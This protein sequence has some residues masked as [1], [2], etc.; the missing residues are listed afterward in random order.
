MT[1]RLPASLKGLKIV[2]CFRAPMGGLFRHVR[3]LVEMQAEAGAMVGVICAR[4]AGDALS[5]DRLLALE[6]H[7][8]LGLHRVRMGRLPGLGDIGAIQQAGAIAGELGADILH[9]HGA[10]GGLYTRL[11]AGGRGVFR[12]YTPHGGALHYS[13][14]SP[15]GLVFHAV[16]RALWAR[17]DGVIFESEYGLETYRSQVGGTP[18]RHAV[19]HNGLR[20]DEF[21]PVAPRADAADFVYLGEMRVL[22]GIATLLE[23]MSQFGGQSRL[24]LVGAG[25]DK[26]F[27]ESK[28][29][30]LGLE[31]R[32]SWY[33]PMPAREAFALGR[34]LVMPSYKESLPYVALEAAAARVPMIATRVGGMAEIFGAEAA[35]LVPAGDVAAL[36][37]A[38]KKNL[39]CRQDE[40]AAEAARLQE[41][42][43]ATF[44][45]KAM[46]EGVAQVYL[47]AM[48]ARHATKPVPA[49]GR[50]LTGVKG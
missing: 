44:S 33:A 21:V 29:K 10:K 30:E 1:E 25:P 4:E 7:C 16:E 27:F 17:T 28:A 45:L 2:H 38:M 32:L 48:E 9:G 42:V 40:A 49:P 47:A 11:A 15:S 50:A 39:S 34:C 22:K 5:E 35:R 26:A 14:M 19:V 3:D 20:E 31:A 12:F 13:R 43:R 6:H 46:A 24:A 18:P 8:A 37:A 23:A 41:H 36:S